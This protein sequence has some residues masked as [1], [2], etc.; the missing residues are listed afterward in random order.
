M[1]PKYLQRL[2][3]PVVDTFKVGRWN[4]DARAN[5][6][7]WRAFA[8]QAERLLQQLG[9]RYTLKDDLRKYLPEGKKPPS[10]P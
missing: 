2:A 9:A 10:I 7:D 3:T 8:Q 5:A 1:N 4:H 6:I